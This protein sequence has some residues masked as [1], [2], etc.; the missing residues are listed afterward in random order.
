MLVM[1]IVAPGDCGRSRIAIA[2]QLLSRGALGP[3]ER[4]TLE[5][6]GRFSTNAGLSSRAAKRFESLTGLKNTYR[7]IKDLAY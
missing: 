2:S 4:P 5:T 3:M 6:T 1:T 7:M